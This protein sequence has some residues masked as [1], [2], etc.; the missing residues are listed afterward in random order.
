[1]VISRVRTLACVLFA[2]ALS[3]CGGGGGGGS[4]SGSDDNNLYVNVAYGN[5]TMQLF[6]ASTIVPTLSGFQGRTPHCNVDSGTLPPGVVMNSD[7]SLSG[8]PTAARPFSFNVLVGEQVYSTN[9]PGQDL[10][11]W[12]YTGGQTR[13]TARGI[14]CPS[15]EG[16]FYVYP[17]LSGLIGKT[18]PAGQVI[19]SDSALVGYLLEDAKVAAVPGVAFGLSPAMRISYATSDALLEEAGERIQRACAALR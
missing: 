6:S 4:G 9:S 14:T 7:C 2:A 18:T 13:A 19:D 1:M 15:P 12:W 8:R 16:A 5:A 3:A 10:T 11:D 17:D